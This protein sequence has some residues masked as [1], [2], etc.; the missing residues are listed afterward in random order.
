MCENIDV[1]IP[2]LTET[3]SSLA[4]CVPAMFTLPFQLPSL[5]TLPVPLPNSLYEL[6]KLLDP[7]SVEYPADA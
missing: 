4:C 3:T 1:I 5:L 2:S 7:D 6:L